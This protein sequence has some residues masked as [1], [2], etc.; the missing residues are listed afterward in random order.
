MNVVRC[1][2]VLLLLSASVGFAQSAAGSAALPSI[3][4]HPNSET[5]ANPYYTYLGH[6]YSIGLFG[7]GYLPLVDA[8]VARSP[9]DPQFRAEVDAYR[10]HVAVGR[11]ILA[12]GALTAAAGVAYVYYETFSGGTSLQVYAG[13]GVGVIGVV[14][15][16]IGENWA[17]EPTA[18]V[19]YYNSHFAAS[20]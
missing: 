4:F 15:G 12:A 8:A 19:D 2:I 7:E 16:L 17:G 14:V 1:S 20:R 6:S 11:G 3:G 13:V 5:V 10:A 9:V 18:I